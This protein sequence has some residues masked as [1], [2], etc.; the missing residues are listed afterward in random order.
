MVAIGIDLGT[1]YSCVGWWKDNRCEIIANDQGNRT[2]PS[3]VAFTESERLIGDGAKNQS[4]MN[5]SN[6]IFDAKRLIGRK[7]N[8]TMVQSDLKHFPFS[9]I[10]QQDKPVIEVEYKGETK[11][12]QPEE[13]SSMVLIKMKE[14]AESYIGEEVT[15]AV[16]TVPA[17]FNDSQ[18]QATKDAG[19]IA[20]LNVLRIINEPTAA[21]IAYGLDKK[22]EE[23]N[24]LIFDLGGGT[25]DVSLLS[26]DDGI[27]EVK[28]TAGDTHLGGE[29]F[30]NLLVKYFTDEFKRKHKLDISDN[31]R[32]IRRLKTAC[33]RA[34][35]TLSSSNT[36]SIELESLFD[37]NDL[38]SSITKAR[39]ES[40]CM[41]LFNRCL[42]PVTKVLQDSGFS[43][44][45]VD[46]I[47]LV[48]GSTRIP[49]VQELLSSYFNGKELNKGIN[50]DEAVAYG[51]AVQAAILS[52]STS[53]DED[54]DKILL[55]DVS[56]LS[57]GIETAGGV[58]TKLIERNTT[59]PTKKS[60]TF[61]TYQD[62]QDS[63]LIQVFEG[64]RTLTKD[65]NELGN[66]KLDGIP[67]APRGIP[68]IE[69]SFDVD[70][71]GIMNI[72]ACDKGSGKKQN[73]TIENDKGRLNSEEIER[74][75]QEAEK[76]KDEDNLV[77]ETIDSKNKLESLLYQTKSSIENT[78]IKAKLD[79][80]DISMVQ[81]SIQEIE[82]WLLEDR[83]KEE[84][85]QK[86]TEFNS[87]INPVMM[88]VYSEGGAM[89]EGGVPGVVPQE[90][91]E[92]PEKPTIDELD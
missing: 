78:E 58:M 69:V 64:E 55:L 8:D 40:L 19:A 92:N 68:Q 62:N 22:T 25:F 77:K 6:T 56:P 15:E 49:K 67:P 23:K 41:N 60:Q 47:V 30:D 50:P 16:I 74:L 1:T 29:D 88:K 52:H 34:K 14:V 75:I 9:V 63:V 42:E 10:N 4:S 21:A 57:L 2:T 35:R 53:G 61:S 76:F 73:I 38:F 12:F 39:F 32:S 46:E 79:E 3:Y 59:I 37:G 90:N 86:T 33:E 24:V 5:P 26:I 66:F 36:A 20:G 85:E 48:G 27:F 65:N 28:A 91:P 84:Y 51:A 45:Q 54:A 44:S 71:N 43:K 7:F 13:I 72:E 83:S 18:R 87:T 89:P 82:E 81:K 11:I 70:A 80:S 17:Y 31:K